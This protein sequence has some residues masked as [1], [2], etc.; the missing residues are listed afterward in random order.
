MAWN[1]ELL[2]FLFSLLKAIYSVGETND[3]LVPIQ[4]ALYLENNGK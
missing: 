4:G 1:K 3:D 2:L